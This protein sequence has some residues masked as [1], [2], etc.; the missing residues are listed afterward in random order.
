MNMDGAIDGFL[1]IDKAA[2]ISSQRAVSQVRKILRTDKAGHTGTLDPLA[3]GVLPLAL[4]EATKLIP[5]LE[6][7]EKVYEV[8][9]CLGQATDTYD[10]E[11]QVTQRGDPK[12]ISKE[13]FHQVL[14]SFLGEYSQV[15]PIFSAVKI[16]GK[17]AYRLARAGQ[18]PAIKARKVR[19]ER[20]EA[21]AYSPPSMSFTVQCSKGTYV[22]SLIHDLGLRLGCYAHL[23]EL[24]R[25]RSGPFELTRAVRVESPSSRE[26]LLQSLLSMEDS[27]GHLPH[28][29]L[30]SPEEVAQTRR[31]QVLPRLNLSLQDPKLW[32]RP[33]ALSFAGQ[34][35]A[36][37][38]S[39][40]GGGY[41][42]KRVLNRKM[43]GEPGRSL[44]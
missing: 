2:G 42:F 44:D 22:R 16:Q 9:A 21:I 30:S 8:Q 24:R 14:L 18:K 28:I 13:K 5:F 20:I 26:D 19:I 34:F 39:K 6:E 3:T 31:G 38:E 25:L 32:G 41:G 1:V 27:L 40:E 35:Q 7:S 4:G 10:R 15:P 11:G 17:P 33:I 36:I 37:I 23:T 43:P 12:G 29:E